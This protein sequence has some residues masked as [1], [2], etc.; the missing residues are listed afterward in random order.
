MSPAFLFGVAVA[1]FLI[2][3]VHAGVCR[4]GG[5]RVAVSPQL[6]LIRLVLFLNLPLLMALAGFFMFR[7]QAFPWARAV[8]TFLFVGI[9]FNSWGYAYFHLFNLSYG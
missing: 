1:P 2:F 9:V 5:S 7:P 4:L 8:Y 3:F 6:S